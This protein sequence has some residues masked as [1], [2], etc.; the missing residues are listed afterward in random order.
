MLSERCAKRSGSLPGVRGKEDPDLGP[1]GESGCLQGEAREQGTPGL[2]RLSDV[3]KFTLACD[4]TSADTWLGSAACT[5]D[6][7]VVLPFPEPQAAQ[8]DLAQSEVGEK[9]EGLELRL[10]SRPTQ[11]PLSHTGKQKRE[12]NI[13]VSKKA[14][15]VL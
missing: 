11:R 7:H 12:A 3:P 13:R 4:W 15:P 1:G 5:S 2:E 8:C 10:W 6:L 9:K 14:E